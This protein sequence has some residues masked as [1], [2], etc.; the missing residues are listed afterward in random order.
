MWRRGSCYRRL[1]EEPQHLSAGCSE[2]SSWD[3]SCLKGCGGN[4]TESRALLWTGCSRGR[5]HDWVCIYKGVRRKRP[6]SGRGWQRWPSLVVA[7]G[8]RRRMRRAQWP[9]FG[10][11]SAVTAER[12]HLAPSWPDAGGWGSGRPR[13]QR[14]ARAAFLLLTTRAKLTLTPAPA[15]PPDLL[16]SWWGDKGPHTGRGRGGEGMDRNEGD[17]FGGGVT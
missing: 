10:L 5:S 9:R 2:G 6:S 11:C 15:S 8:G 17:L 4:F 3:S 12:S 7:G 13:T 16:S 1:H 14:P